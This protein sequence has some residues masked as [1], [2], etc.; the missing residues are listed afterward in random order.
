M[1]TQPTDPD[2][3]QQFG[4]TTYIPLPWTALPILAPLRYLGEQTGLSFLTRPLADL[5]QPVMTVLI[6]TGYDRTS[7]GTPTPFRL[8]PIVNPVTLGADLV[9]ATLQGIRDAIGDIDGTRPAPPPTQDPFATAASLFSGSDGPPV[10]VS[11]ARA[12]L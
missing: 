9:A 12:H 2:N 6:E 8:I 5:V 1:H 7:Y 11:T 3:A 4:N 10:P